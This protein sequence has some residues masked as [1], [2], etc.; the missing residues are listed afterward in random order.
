MTY[1]RAFLIN[2]IFKSSLGRLF[3]IHCSYWCERAGYLTDVGVGQCSTEAHNS[4]YFILDVF[5]QLYKVLIA[6]VGMPGY[7]VNAPADII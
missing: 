5:R 7:M 4:H 1:V 2:I 6:V 3:S